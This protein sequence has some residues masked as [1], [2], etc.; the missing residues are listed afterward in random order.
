[1]STPFEK[2]ENKIQGVLNEVVSAMSAL[3]MEP[4][5]LKEPIGNGFYLSERDG[6]AAHCMEHLRAVF[7]LANEAYQERESD[8]MALFRKDEALAA[9]HK[10]LSKPKPEPEACY[11][12]G[13]IDTLVCSSC[14]SH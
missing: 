14:R 13:K 2:Y 6:W 10:A 12:G 8:R 11:C 7:Q 9:C 1:M 4:E 3:N 5:P